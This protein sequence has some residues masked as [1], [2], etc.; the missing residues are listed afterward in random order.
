MRGCHIKN[1]WVNQKA[2]GIE[3][4]I[5]ISVP[6][7]QTLVEKKDGVSKYTA[8]NIHVNGFFHAAVRFSILHHFAETVRQRF[9][10]RFKGPEFPPKR[11]FR[12]LDDRALEDRKLKIAKWLSAIIQHPEITQNRYVEKSFLDF[13][14]DSYR[15]TSSCVSL[16]V[17]LGDGEKIII[18]CNVT[19]ST[20]EVMQLIAESLGCDHERFV[21]CFGLFV[22]KEREKKNMESSTS[23]DEGVI[24]LMSIRLLRNFESPYVSVQLLNQK[25]AGRGVLHKMTIRKLI[26]DP[27]LEELL[28][29]HPVF[30]KLLFAQAKGDFLN[31]NLRVLNNET[32]EIMKKLILQ[33]NG[34][35]FVRTCHLQ[36]GYGYEVLSPCRSDHPIPNTQ[37]ELMIGRR[38]LVLSFRLHGEQGSNQSVFRATRIRVWRISQ[39][40]TSDDPLIFQFEYLMS[41]DT[42]EWITLYT[43]QAILLSL[44]L[45][46]IGTEIL[47]ENRNNVV[48]DHF[49]T[50]ERKYVSNGDSSHDDDVWKT[51]QHRNPVATS[52]F[53]PSE[54]QRRGSVQS[55]SSGY[56]AQSG[57]VSE[58]ANFG[59]N[60]DP[61]GVAQIYESF[62]DVFTTITDVL[63]MQNEA[64]NNI[65]D[66]DL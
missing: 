33:E 60:V 52:A 28:M 44:L 64:F 12:T 5:H 66:D 27:R 36:P 37:C 23:N 24:D 63:P 62:Q 26:W 45:Q 58:T 38:Q 50:K 55:S 8:Y 15:P 54:S 16:D 35:Q 22:A 20:N 3:G 51:V 49:V 61:L 53:L 46:S 40:P 42:F 17:Y 21:E 9:G 14:I 10:S 2:N 7:A 34:N 6:D 47:L 30:S 41:K 57:A 25:S 29:D 56:S 43:N 18:K 65:T 48:E 32:K 19:H 39:A 4:M 1:A 59:A 31:G 11:I 13:Q